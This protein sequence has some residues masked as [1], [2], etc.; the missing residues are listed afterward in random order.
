[1]DKKMC[2]WVNPPDPTTFSIGVFDE[3]PNLPHPRIYK[4]YGGNKMNPYLVLI[5]LGIDLICWMLLGY[6][7]SCMN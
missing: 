6:L 7:I 2:V 1:M 4:C 5:I 3:L